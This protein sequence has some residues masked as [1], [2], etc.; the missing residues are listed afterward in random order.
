MTEAHCLHAAPSAKGAKDVSPGQR[1]GH[2]DANETIALKV[3]H[4]VL[5]PGELWCPFR[6]SVATSAFDPGRCPGLAN[7]ALSGPLR[8]R[9]DLGNSPTEDYPQA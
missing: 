6:A 9:T 5:S 2:E 1:P 7:S 3:R 8:P 4:N